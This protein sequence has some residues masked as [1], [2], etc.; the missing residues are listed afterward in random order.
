MTKAY[1]IY[2][3][4]ILA[5]LAFGNYRGWVFINVAYPNLRQHHGEGVNHK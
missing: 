3:I 5:L 4:L 2:G 1:L